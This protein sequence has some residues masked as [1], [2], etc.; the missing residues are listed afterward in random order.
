MEEIQDSVVGGSQSNAEF[1][2]AVTQ[3]VGFRSAEFV[4]QRCEALEPNAAFV[5]RFLWELLE[6]V[7]KWC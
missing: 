6:P 3:E 5:L 4:P 2:D 7:E 1:V